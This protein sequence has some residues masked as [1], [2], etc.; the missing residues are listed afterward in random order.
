MWLIEVNASPSL[1]ADTDEDY[2][3]KYGLCE[4][5]L[6]VVDIEGKL[7]GDEKN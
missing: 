1:S 4:D 3:L 2:E 5:T 7:T 6:D